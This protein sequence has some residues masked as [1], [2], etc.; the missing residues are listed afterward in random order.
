MVVFEAFRQSTSYEGIVN[1]VRV[2]GM[3]VLHLE[4]ARVAV[5]PGGH[6]NTMP[7]LQ[8]LYQFS[9]RMRST[10]HLASAGDNLECA[11]DIVGIGISCGYWLSGL[12]DSSGLFNFELSTFSSRS[13]SRRTRS[14]GTRI[15]SD[16]A[17][18][19]WQRHR[20][21]TP[22]RVPRTN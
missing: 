22:R 10:A 20:C 7:F 15:L 4:H 16:F 3:V 5:W 19:Y 17:R 9:G 8:Y 2:S 21:A 6:H 18:R 14:F 1:E 12:D 11:Q 13:S